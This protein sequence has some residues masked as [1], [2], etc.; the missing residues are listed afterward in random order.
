MATFTQAVICSV[1]PILFVPM[2]EMYGL[3]Y[4]QLGILVGVNFVSQV[5]VD[6]LFSG[7]IDK[8]GYRRFSLPAML[9]AAAGLLLFAAA[10]VFF[11]SNIYAGLFLATILFAAAGGLL[12]VMTSPM[13]NAIP[14]ENKGTSM[15]LLHGF[16]C[17][18]QV[19]AVVVTTLFL[20]FFGGENWQ[21]I[22]LLWVLVPAANFFV[23]LRS[24]FPPAMPPEKR[25]RPKKMLT[26][27]FFLISLFA[28]MCGACT[29]L[30][31]AQWSSAYMEKALAL[32]KVAG[33]L[34]GLCGFAVFMGVGRTLYGVRGE[35]W[36]MSRILVLCG[37]LAFIC[38]LT[39]A[40][41]PFNGLNVL[42]CALCGLGASLMWPGTLVVCSE[43]FPMG[44][45][46][47]FAILAAAGDIGGSVG[48]WLMGVIS[49]NAQSWGMTLL[50][51]PS[52]TPEQAAMRAGILVCSLFPLG[53]MVCHAVLG[54]MLQK[55][56]PETDAS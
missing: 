55:R 12:E 6:I 2:M 32:P 29:E 51:L 27:P 1:T 15:S 9:I 11:S 44:G 49:D 7:M 38:Y 21:I 35:K 36:R 20:W 4:T 18:G 54:R 50:R 13:I 31:L 33:D 43:R 42:V 45:A 40:L 16:Y 10:P 17:W 41:S 19:I 52:L 48:P 30:I 56:P 25:D 23:F 14:S 37:A 24:T 28:I 47:M 34:L 3:S 22:V 5:A 8:Y 26:S 39:V 46:W 53:A